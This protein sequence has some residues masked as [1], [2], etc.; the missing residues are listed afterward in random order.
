M[1]VQL[2]MLIKPYN[3][4]ED[5]SKPKDTML[6][7]KRKLLMVPFAEVKHQKED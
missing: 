6:R 7:G 4:R 5:I 2:A 3:S 1:L